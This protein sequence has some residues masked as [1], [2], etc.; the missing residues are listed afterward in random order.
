MTKAEFR[1]FYRTTRPRLLAWVL[2]RVKDEHDAEEVVQDA[3]LAFIDSLP[4]YQGKSSLSTFLYSI[5]KHEVADYW[6]KKYAKKAILTVPFVDQVYTERL[7]S[8]DLT[9]A[10]IEKVY[11]QLTAEQRLILVMKYEENKAVSEIAERLKI[12]IKAAESRLF[13]AR[14]AFKLAFELANRV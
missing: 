5:A 12:S 3:Y 11:A 4:L 14:N 7:Y 6:R 1:R 10:E 8:A 2:S 13:R 9:A